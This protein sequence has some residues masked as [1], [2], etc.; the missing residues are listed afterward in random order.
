MNMRRYQCSECDRYGH[1]SRTCPQLGKSVVRP[2]GPGVCG[3]GTPLTFQAQR[4]RACAA[5][6]RN[7]R[8]SRRADG[9][10]AS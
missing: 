9:R 1:N 7:K 5:I 6:E 4:C 8:R 3:C 2:R 10:F